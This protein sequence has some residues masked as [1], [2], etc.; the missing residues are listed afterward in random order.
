MA[1]VTDAP[2]TTPAAVRHSLRGTLPAWYVLAL[3]LCG[4]A[5]AWYFTH[6]ATVREAS[7]RFETEIGV[8]QI[9]LSDRL[10]A[11]EQ[12][13]RGGVSAFHSWPAVT[14]ENWHL[15]VE[16]LQIAENYPGIQGIGFAQV[17]SPAEKVAHT[18]GIRNEGFPDYQIWPEG[19]RAI[20]TSIIYLEPFDWR[21]QRAFGYDMLSEPVRRAAMERARDTGLASLSGRVTLVQETDE[22]VQVGFLVYLP[23]YRTASQADV[24]ER[25]RAL[26]G[27]VY[28]P[29]RMDDFMRGLL[30]DRQRHVG[31]EIFDGEA[32]SE[33][34]LMYSNVSQDEPL[35]LGNAAFVETVPL[36]LSGR[37][38]TLRF[39]SLPSLGVD[40][41]KPLI[42]L[43]GGVLVSFLLAAIAWSLARNRA[44]A[45]A[46]NLRLQA[47]IER[48]KGIEAQLREKETSFRYLFE[49]NP[50]PMWVFDRGTLSILEVN[51]A[52]VARYGYAHDE[53]RRLRITDLRPAEDVPRLVSY[54]Q[55]R[56]AGLKKAG[57]WQHV[58]KD[59]RTIDVE[60]TSYTLDFQHR[61]A[62]LVVARDI[63]ES[64][65]AE[66]AL[67]E[68]EAVARGVLDAALDAYVRMDQ[69]GRITEW[70]VMAEAIFGWARTEA[71]GRSV[72]DTIIPPDHRDAHH[73]GLAR[74]LAT[75]E[76]PVLNRRIELQAL[77][78]SGKAF[79]VELTIMA[80]NTD[81][82]RVFSAFIRD[83]TERRR[84]E[85]HLRQAQ[86][87]EAVGQLTGGV[88]H[89]FNNLLTVII[90]SLELAGGRT[91]ND[92]Q[93]IDLINQALSA[94]DKGAALTHRL[95]AFSRLQAL[96]PTNTDL[97]Q[98][99]TGMTDLLRRTLGEQVEID[100]RLNEELWT[101]LADRSQVE[102]ALLNLAINSRD[103]MPGGGKLT[104]ETA[105]AP[106][107]ADY[108]ARN[109]EV[110]PGD[111]IVLAV[112][113]T[114]VGMP[115]EV[116][117]RA[118]E[119]FFTTKDIGK[120]SGLGLSMIY[121]F[122]KQSGGHLKIY[123][124]LG[125]GTTVRLYLPRAGGLQASVPAPGTPS[126][127]QRGSETILVVE[128]DADVR[129]LAVAQ[130]RS[131]GYRVLE[132]PD[133]MRAIALLKDDESIDLLFTD[134]IMPGGM[135]GRQL[136]EE[137]CRLRPGMK[138][139]FT[140]GYT[141]NSIVHQGKLDH[142]VHLLSKP[143]RRDGLARKIR[144]MLDSGS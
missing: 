59:G 3:S 92:P 36:D 106:L 130:L 65:R 26:M 47:D 51:D 111:Y 64:K 76:G 5:A 20:Y 22:A 4:T 52:A 126:E 39:S 80:L 131:L 48:R 50:N 61:A 38:W 102:S 103:A 142:G 123:S 134:V 11:Y 18:L 68:S 34:A 66:A 105:N 133:G 57:E 97:N 29:F 58:T 32:P 83:L 86:K 120:G 42:V 31:L 63:T 27:Y 104:I 138:V 98:I 82:G 2:F 115:P 25:R 72:A 49:K 112:S 56:P 60:V 107:D 16:N 124:E 94:A 119:P 53:F 136:A 1:A 96:Q 41:S 8:V 78:R 101:A 10:R 17:V 135:T 9:D 125:H 84:A 121:G 128:D 37:T 77:H 62:V 127:G 139:L 67:R 99:V 79:P 13:L 28:S 14:R 75:G 19:E 54:L 93:L 132:A 55:N 137:G 73:R 95:L 143:Y 45:A 122:A 100:T 90:G 33:G 116:V 35:P 108:A 70:N 118:F 88:A 21:N 87:M 71:I 15:F 46:A 43:G 69:D 44:Q 109:A 30:G 117:E 24:E 7:S 74:F 85:E 110:T 129:R 40:R 81:R 6:S 91:A 89:D 141:Q 144:E 23:V 113:D 140:S 114:G 12:V